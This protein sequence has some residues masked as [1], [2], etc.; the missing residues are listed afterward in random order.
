M[1]H[2]PTLRDILQ[3]VHENREAID[4]LKDNA[5]TK[6]DLFQVEQR[7]DKK[8]NRFQK[9]LQTEITSVRTELNQEIQSVKKELSQEITSVRK[10]MNKEIRSAKTELYQ[11]ITLVRTELK[12]D[13]AVLR[14]EIN[15][16]VDDFIG[17]YQ[18]QESDLA[19]VSLRQQ[20]VEEKVDLMRV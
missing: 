12:T 4:F 18:K 10:D 11:E 20:R 5:A 17:L 9:E 6:D 7:L 1:E 8:I 19:A 2:E 13:I 15:N 14:H 3:A 16:H